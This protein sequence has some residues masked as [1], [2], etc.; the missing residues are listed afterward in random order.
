[1]LV[2]GWLDDYTEYEV[3]QKVGQKITKSVSR[4]VKSH[5]R[6]LMHTIFQRALFWEMLDKNPINLVHQSQKRMRK[7]RALMIEGFKLLVPQLAEPYKTIV[8][9]HQCLGL[10]VC[11]TVAL[12][13]GDISFENLT[14]H[15]QR[16]F[17]RGEVNSVK[18]AK[19]DSALPLDPDLA[20]ILLQHK[21]HAVYTTDTDYVFAGP[22]G[23]IRWP[24]SML[25]D[26]IKPA[27]GRAGIG[28]VGWHTFR[29]TYS[30]LLHEL[31]A[32]PAVQQ[33]LLR[34]A[35]IRTTMNL[36]TQ[37]IPASTR[38]AASMAVKAL[39]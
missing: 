35:D 7:P 6:N 25:H 16:S 28:N 22:T 12:Q 23:A 31:G 9:V 2:E 30:T 27:A 15:I 13:W 17:V 38:E 33:E 5:I 32:K 20:T 4:A 29:H 1:M 34:H 37:A 39:L 10:R 21:A 11:E 26:H 18:T 14:V 8:I 24:E 3:E 19:S 36:Y